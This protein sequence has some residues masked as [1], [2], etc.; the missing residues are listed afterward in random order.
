MNV[1]IVFDHPRRDS[2]CGAVLD[3]FEAGLTAP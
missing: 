1:L 3:A 2:F